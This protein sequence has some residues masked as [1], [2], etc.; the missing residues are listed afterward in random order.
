VNRYVTA[1]LGPSHCGQPFTWF[2]LKKNGGSS[3]PPALNLW[4]L[5]VVASMPGFGVCPATTAAHRPQ[6]GDWEA[7]RETRVQLPAQ[8][9]LK[10]LLNARMV[11]PTVEWLAR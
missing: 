4:T 6:A 3:I 1:L 2:Y 7:I 9:L 11:P 8:L 5:L 10:T